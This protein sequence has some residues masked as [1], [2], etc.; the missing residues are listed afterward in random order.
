MKLIN[1]LVSMLKSPDKIC[2]PLLL[3]IIM[4]FFKFFI[5]FSIYKE[6]TKEGFAP[7][8]FSNN[9]NNDNNNNNNDNKDYSK[10]NKDDPL[11]PHC[12]KDLKLSLV[13]AIN[14]MF[15]LYV[16][17]GLFLHLLCKN[18]MKKAAWFVILYPFLSKFVWMLII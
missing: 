13:I 8:D 4:G 16:I 17:F 18:D 1:D 6:L 11:C 15:Y 14:F 12:K 7:V 5:L 10:C 2:D 9:N 3:Y